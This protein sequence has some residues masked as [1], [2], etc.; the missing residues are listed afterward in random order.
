MASLEFRLPNLGMNIEEAEIEEWHV[1]VGEEIGEGQEIVSVGTDKAQT[2]L[3]APF[4]GTV[5][6]IHA[7]AGQTVTVGS[8]LATIEA[9]G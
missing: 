8:L 3:P 6:A 1:E 2:E 9:R 5:R 4:A 7:A